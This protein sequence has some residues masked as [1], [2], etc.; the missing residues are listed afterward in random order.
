MK[1]FT[2]GCLCGAVRYEITADAGPS[3]ICWCKDCQKIASNGTVNVIYQIDLKDP[4]GFFVLKSFRIANR[5]L[6]YIANSS[7][8]EVRKF[9]TLI[10]T[11][12]SPVVQGAAFASSLHDLSN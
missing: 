4:A 11:T 10:S 7:L 9:S 3:R 2:G 6:I 12:A 8:A 1:S 5:D